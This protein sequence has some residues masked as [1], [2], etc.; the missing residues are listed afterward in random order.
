MTEQMIDWEYEKD[1]IKAQHWINNSVV[2]L[3]NETEV[4]YI[5]G[6]TIA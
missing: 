2:G 3:V 1:S 4:K 5:T 6:W